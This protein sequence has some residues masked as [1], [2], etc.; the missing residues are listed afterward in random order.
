MICQVMKRSKIARELL[1]H[2][3]FWTFNKA[4]SLIKPTLVKLNRDLPVSITKLNLR[5]SRQISSIRTRRSIIHW[6]VHYKLWA[7]CLRFPL[8]YLVQSLD[9]T[10]TTP[11]QILPDLM[12]TKL[13]NRLGNIWVTLKLLDQWWVALNKIRR[14]FGNKVISWNPILKV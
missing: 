1:P 2:I 4:Q 3:Y 5:R 11:Q 9:T 7:T 14:I 8:L 12:K 13:S 10:W 6:P